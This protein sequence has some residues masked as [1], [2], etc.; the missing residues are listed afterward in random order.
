MP[1]G[2]VSPTER[3]RRLVALA[4]VVIP[5]LLAAVHSAA[6]QKATT[7]TRILVIYSHDMNA[8]GVLAF[9][10]QFRDVIRAGWSQQAEFYNEALDFDRFGY[11]EN[12]PQFAA[13]LAEK[14][15]RFP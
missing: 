15:R 12:W 4:G 6:G 1:R 3:A 9:S 2:R 13:Y 8:P 11:G 10:R 5:L 7:P 14:Y